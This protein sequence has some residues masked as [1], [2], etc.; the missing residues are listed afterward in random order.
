LKYSEKT[1]SPDYFKNL[2]KSMVFMKKPITKQ[3]VY[4]NF[5]IKA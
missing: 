2:R 5:T 1:T 4:L 3:A